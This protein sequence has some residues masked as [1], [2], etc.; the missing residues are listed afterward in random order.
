MLRGEPSYTG[1]RMSGEIIGDAAVTIC[2]Q[3]PGVYTG[4][5]LY[6]E[7]VML[8][9]GGLPPEDLARRYPVEP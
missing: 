3:E 1:W 9:E 8:K 5:I 6:D 2:A 7:L 4:N